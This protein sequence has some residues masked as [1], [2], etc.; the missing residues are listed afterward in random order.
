[1]T[2]PER[3][4]LTVGAESRFPEYS[5]AL[6]KINTIATHPIG[7]VTTDAIGERLQLDLFE[8]Y[9]QN[10]FSPTPL[11]LSVARPRCLTIPQ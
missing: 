1:M 11:F 8:H 9:R 7:G 4:R 5:N 2:Y 6:S 3:N 10:S